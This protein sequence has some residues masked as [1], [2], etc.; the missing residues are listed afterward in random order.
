MTRA[1]AL[2][3]HETFVTTVRIDDGAVADVVAEMIR[4]ER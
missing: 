3:Q 1:M 2:P 4:S